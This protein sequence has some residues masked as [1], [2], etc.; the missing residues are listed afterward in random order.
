MRSAPPRPLGAQGSSDTPIG[1]GKRCTAYGIGCAGGPVVRALVRVGTAGAPPRWRTLSAAGAAKYRIAMRVGRLA[2]RTRVGDD[3][4]GIRGF[5]AQN[6]RRHGSAVLELMRHHINKMPALQIYQPGGIAQIPRLGQ[7]VR[8]ANDTARQIPVAMSLAPPFDIVPDHRNI[9]SRL[10]S[11]IG[12]EPRS[13]LAAAVGAILPD[14]NFGTVGGASCARNRG[15]RA[16][17][18]CGKRPPPCDQRPFQ[19]RLY[20]ASPRPPRRQDARG[21]DRTGAILASGLANGAADPR[22]GR[23][24][25]ESGGKE[26]GAAL[27]RKL[28]ESACLGWA[29]RIYGSAELWPSGRRH[30]PAKGADGEPSRGFESLRLRHFTFGSGW[31][32]SVFRSVPALG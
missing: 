3:G 19:G 31:F 32:C 13:G 25:R 22:R 1:G 17:G 28:W 4:N 24:Q 12:H 16:R 8:G 21:P 26:P 29:C 9:E 20:P 5:D 23:H 7:G 18:S 14:L 6:S 30:T 27:C 10:A 2:H 11:G 15:A